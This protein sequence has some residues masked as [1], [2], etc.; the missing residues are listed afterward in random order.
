MCPRKNT[1]CMA[2]AE[3][4]LGYIYDVRMGIITFITSVV[5]SQL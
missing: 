1:E 4:V 2:C 3:Q 5:M